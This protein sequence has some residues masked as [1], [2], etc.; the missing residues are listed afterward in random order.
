MKVGSGGK[1]GLSREYSKKMF[2]PISYSWCNCPLNHSYYFVVVHYFG[3]IQM[4]NLPLLTVYSKTNS[5]LI[6]VALVEKYS[7]YKKKDRKTICL[8]TFSVY[9]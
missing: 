8:Y 5:D 1:F 2:G 6:Y 3:G 4:S 9:F 7:Q